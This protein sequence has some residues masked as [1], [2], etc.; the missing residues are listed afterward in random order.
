MMPELPSIAK[1]ARD[2]REGSL[3]ACELVEH[4][5]S[6]LVGLGIDNAVVEV[7]GPEL[8]AGDG[9]ASIFVDA[10]RAAGIVSQRVP[11]EPLV[12]REPVTVRDDHAVVTALPAEGADSEFL[13]V[14]DYGPA[15]PLGR[16]VHSFTLCPATYAEQIAPARTFSTRTTARIAAS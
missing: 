2:M 15:S 16:Q 1:A 6:A 3:T 11:R 8:P 12:I 7:T 4:C 5:L 9:S 13:Y 14:L 10:I